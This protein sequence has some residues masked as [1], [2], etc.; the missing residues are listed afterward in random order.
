MFVRM[1]SVLRVVVAFAVVVFALA[2]CGAGG[3]SGGGSS[4]GATQARGGAS[5][6][7]VTVTDSLGRK[8][9][10]EKKPERIASMAPSIT[11]TLFAI[12]AGKRV[13]GVTTADDYPPQVEHI[14]KIGDY[15]GVN[16]EK[17]ASLKTDVLFMSFATTRQQAADLEKKTGAKVVVI[18]PESVRGAIASIGTVGKVV[19]DEKK[20]REVQRHMRREL[21]QVRK[22][23]RGLSHPTV[24]YE[25]Y[26]KPLQTAGPGSFIDDEIKLAGGKNVAAGAKSAYPQYSLEELVKQN[27][28]YYLI[29]SSSGDTPKKVASRPGFEALK[30]V[31]EGH[32][33]VINDNLTTR[34]GPRIVEGVKQIA[35]AIHPGAFKVH[36]KR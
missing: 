12:G 32:V 34:P 23:V 2:G 21:S 27:P 5:G 36:S 30:A 26:P 35:E 29:G 20:A 10:I 4:G 17:V 33:E 22:E 19:G 25:V 15:K 24:F 3:V 13:V 31:R 6:Y 18:N 9:T 28:D 14:T 7:P 1:V 16:A 8:V 11:E